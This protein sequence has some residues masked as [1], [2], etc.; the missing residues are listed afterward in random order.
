MTLLSWVALVGFIIGAAGIPIVILMGDVIA[1]W[2]QKKGAAPAAATAGPPATAASVVATAE[3][4][5][6]PPEPSKPEPSPG[7]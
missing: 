4:P 3:A 1:K 7:A 2:G 5:V 6:A